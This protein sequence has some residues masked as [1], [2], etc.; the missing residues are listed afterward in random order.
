[1]HVL[2]NSWLT[3][4]TIRTILDDGKLE[5]SGESKARILAARDVVD[6]IVAS[7]K[8][9][10]GINTRF[11]KFSET[12]IS[13]HE[14]EE[15]QRRIVLSHACGV[16]EPIP[17]DI[18]KLM[19]LLKIQSLC[20]G[21]SGCSLSVVELLIEMFNKNIIPVVPSKGSVGASGDLAPLSHMALAMI[22]EGNC[23]VDGKI[24]DSL[25]A[26]KSAGLKPITLGAK[27]GLA[28]LNG[29][30]TMGA[31]LTYALLD[32]EDL[33]KK[34]TK[35]AALT[36]EALTGTAAAFDERIHAVRHQVGQAQ[37][38]IE[39]RNLLSG[40]ELVDSR[41]QVQDA[42]SLRCIPQVHGAVLDTFNHVKSVLE[43]ELNGVTDNP[44][45][46]SE[47]GDVISG[48]NFHGEPLAL[49]ADFMSI[50]VAE[51]AS[52]SERR[53]AH[54]VDP[55]VSN[56]PAFLV[57]EG[58]LNSGYMIP[59][60]TAAALVSE[61]KVLAHP[62]S[63]DSVPTS[64]NKEDHVSMGTHATRKLNTIVENTW[65]V[66]S[67]ELLC[68]AQG[69]DLVGK[70]QSPLLAKFKKGLRKTVP[71]WTTDRLMA[72]DMSKCLAYLRK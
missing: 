71:V 35:V 68:A 27:D 23:F 20:Y 28:I 65:H 43:R 4:E 58:G 5:L 15:L 48:G 30:Q 18:C 64:A 16:G 11:G 41:Q 10:Y 2:T 24:V 55:H 56:L 52:I 53:I 31:Y 6:K 33:F 70:K 62:A 66:L 72:D 59:Q 17:T 34:A 67:I 45:V 42:Y 3:L 37:V 12:K 21:H 40:S 38:A 36:I 47:S 49:V 25:A 63:V 32:I 69:V 57:K 50:A 8:T 22:G 14:I 51:L 60:Y 9:V 1:M 26:L 46:F 44:L 19:M 29:T 61:N 54:M 13:D 39:I 7:G